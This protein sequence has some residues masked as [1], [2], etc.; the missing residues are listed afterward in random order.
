M[1]R[2]LLVPAL[3]LS[4]TTTGCFTT[5]GAVA[6]SSAKTADGKKDPYATGRGVLV[7]AVIDAALIAV[8]LSS[9]DFGFASDEDG[10]VSR[11]MPPQ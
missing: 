4:L 3:L 7:G 11:A 5:L 10:I 8:I 6:G 1:K 2:Y 9:A